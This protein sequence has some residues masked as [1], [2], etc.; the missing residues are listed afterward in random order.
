MYN[1]LFLFY[2]AKE[3]TLWNKVL[4]LLAASVLAVFFSTSIFSATTH[5]GTVGED[6]TEI[7]CRANRLVT[8]PYDT[9]HAAVLCTDQPYRV[10]INFN[11]FI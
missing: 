5:T 2:G 11:Y 10:V 9:F 3:M 1:T 8:Y 7:E 6:G 4:Y